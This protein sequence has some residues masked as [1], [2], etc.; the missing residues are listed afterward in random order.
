[1]PTSKDFR[2][3]LFEVFR[4]GA[5]QGQSWVIV[6]AADLHRQSG[7]YPNGGNHRMAGCCGVMLRAMRPGDVIVSGPPK[8]RGA[9]LTIRYQTAGWSDH[10]EKR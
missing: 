4:A 3:L 2:D 9:S 6:K 5:R 7:E 10:E 1:M 8:G